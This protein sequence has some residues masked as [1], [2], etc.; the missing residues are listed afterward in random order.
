MP[1]FSIG[2]SVHSAAQTD[3]WSME[4]RLVAASLPAPGLGGNDSLQVDVSG[5]RHMYSGTPELTG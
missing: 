5:I 1:W 4:L 3:E 2:F